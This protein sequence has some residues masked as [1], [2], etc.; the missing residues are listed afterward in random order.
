[1][2]QEMKLRSIVSDTYR[3][4]TS[5][6]GTVDNLVRSGVDTESGGKV[7]GD[8]KAQSILAVLPV[9]DPFRR[10][11]FPI[12]WDCKGCRGGQKDGS[13]GLNLHN[14]KVME[15]LSVCELY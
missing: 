1:M 3:K 9:F 5:W 12:A 4:A 2:S 6:G 7:E 10:I 13:D 8:V 15:F 14:D 11:T